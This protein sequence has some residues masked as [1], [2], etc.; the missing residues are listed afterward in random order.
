MVARISSISAYALTLVRLLLNNSYS[1]LLLVV[2]LLFIGELKS[3]PSLAF[4]ATVARL[5]PAGASEKAA[6]DLLSAAPWEGGFV[7]P[8]EINSLSCSSVFLLYCTTSSH[9][10]N[11]G[12]S[13][14]LILTASGLRGFS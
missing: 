13:S 6:D 7:S 10:Y 1:A 2:L 3:R 14:K 12:S 4:E 11:V 9:L 8:F 5:A